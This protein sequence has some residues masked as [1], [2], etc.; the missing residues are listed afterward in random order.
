MADLFSITAPLMIRFANGDEQVIAHHFKHAKGLLYFDL[1][2]HL[3]QPQDT[4]HI[5]EGEVKGDGPWKIGE[6]VI[7]VLG[8]HGTNS[9]LATRYEQW[10][11]FLQQAEADYPAEGL[12]HAIARKLGAQ[13][14]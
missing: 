1:Y 13:P 6:Y 9:E 8:C 2:W 11:T 10:Q 14:D 5:V 12:I 7:N 4:I 3:G